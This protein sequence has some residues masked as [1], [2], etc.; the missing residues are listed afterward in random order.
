MRKR[1]LWV[2]SILFYV[3]AVAQQEPHYTQYVMNQYIIN[4]AITGIENYTDIKI[5]HRHQWAGFEGAPVTTYFTAHKA[6]GK[7][8]SKTTA[9]SF[10]GESGGSPR[11]KNYWEQY[12]AAEPHHG[13]G[14]QIID[15]KTGP[16]SN[17]K[18]ALTY[19]YHLGLTDKTSIAAG[20]GFGISQLTLN[21]T[22]A[23][24]GTINVDPSVYSSGALSKIHP[25]LSAGLYLYSAD[26]F[27]GVSALQIVPQRI[28][29]SNN[30]VKVQAN[31]VLPHFFMTAGYRLLLSD[32]LNFI[33]SLM[34]KQFSATPTQ[35]EFNGKLQYR[36]IFWLGASYRSEDAVAAMVGVNL[37]NKITMGYSY[38]YTT[39]Y[40][41][42]FSHG[43]HEIMIGFIIGNGWD[44]SCPKNVW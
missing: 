6:F 18:A 8:D 17:L 20:F 7:T 11:G 40:L 14:L 15:D 29:Y 27:L 22:K 10:A 24:F 5:S 41:N 37:S 9:T 35:I 39:S 32:D 30:T 2:V 38:D 25:D 1:L 12:T 31:N 23:N 44:D 21:A 34:V 4:P 28:D 36:D 42:N 33:P 26:F 19:A 16:L 3:S 43:S 13:I